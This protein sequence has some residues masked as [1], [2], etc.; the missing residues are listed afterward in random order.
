[1]IR[2]ILSAWL[3]SFIAL[4]LQSTWLQSL[5]V[6][7]VVPDLA[8]LI[9]IWVSYENSRAEGPI[10]AFLAGIA[11]DFLGS[12]PV[13]FGPF[14]FTLAAWLAS[15]LHGIVRMDR[16]ILPCVMGFTGTLV[17]VLGANMLALLFGSTKITAR[18]FGDSGVWIE[19]G[20]NAVIAPLLF[21]GLGALKRWLITEEHRR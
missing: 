14:I 18:P 17:K 20:L 6:A 21:I 5:A 16:I 10:A 7:G 12:G 9:L 19:A 13:G 11:F 1:M 15:V 2:T 8:L 3:V 4:V